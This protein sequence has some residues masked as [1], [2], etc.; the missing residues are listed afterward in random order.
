MRAWVMTTLTGIDVGTEHL[1]KCPDTVEKHNC[2]EYCTLAAANARSSERSVERALDAATDAIEPW[3]FRTLRI[4]CVVLWFLRPLRDRLLVRFWSFDCSL[5]HRMYECCTWSG[6]LMV[7]DEQLRQKAAAVACE[8]L[9]MLGYTVET[10]A[11][12]LCPGSFPV[13]GDT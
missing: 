6:T 5:D 3:W 7:P 11:F 1:P 12:N 2:I 8:T 4:V 10:K 9:R 13:V